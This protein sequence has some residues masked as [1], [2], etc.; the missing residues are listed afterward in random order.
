[1]FVT[2][3]VGILRSPHVSPHAQGRQGPG[4]LVPGSPVAPPSHNYTGLS[5]PASHLPDLR[6]PPE[7]LRLHRQ[8]GQNSQWSGRAL[9]MTMARKENSPGIQWVVYTKGNHFE[10]FRVADVLPN[11]RRQPLGD[12]GLNPSSAINQTHGTRQPRSY[13]A[14]QYSHL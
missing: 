7:C 8:R 11:P 9:G 2:V 13:P 10:V 1:M 6:T 4:A 5:R 14:P 12:M 3:F